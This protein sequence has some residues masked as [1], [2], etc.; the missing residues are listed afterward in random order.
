MPEPG[1]LRVAD[2]STALAALTQ[3]GRSARLIAGGTDLVNLIKEG[4]E[5]PAVLVDIGRLP[6][7]TVQADG[8]GLRIGALTTMSAAA[9]DPALRSGYPA[10][11]EAL[12]LSASPQ[13]RNAATI[14][15]NLLQRTRCPYY[16]AE[17]KLPCNKR[18][19]G[20]G[21]AARSGYDRTLAVIGWSDACRACHPSDLA[22][23]LVALNAEL[24]IHSPR[25]SRTVPLAAFYRLPGETPERD[26][27]LEPD[28]IVIA[29]R[30]PPSPAAACSGYLKVRERAPYEFGLVSAAVAVEADGTMIRDV[31]ICLGGVAARPWRLYEVER[32]L[33]G[34]QLTESVVR[35]AL[36]LALAD[37]RPLKSNG[38]KI[39]LARRAACRALLE[40]RGRGA[41]SK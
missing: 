24:T 10:V 15:G 40:L 33:V 39:E 2:T 7:D 23:A 17:T 19:P 5:R 25:G 6:L 14:G 11:V 12:E 37:A 32:Y 38:F 29:V 4:I 18:Q 20:S 31:R 8:N 9:G 13:I 22:V 28:E 27:V 1:Y 30:V 35:E 21:C 26:S 34:R 36:A 41:V 3:Y 16:R